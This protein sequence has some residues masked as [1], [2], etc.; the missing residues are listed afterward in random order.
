MGDDAERP[1][2]PELEDW[3]AWVWRCWERLR[4]DRQWIAA[5]MEAMPGRIPWSTIDRWCERHGYTAEEARFLERCLAALDV[6]FLDRWHT[7]RQG[8]AKRG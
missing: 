2:G 8:A 3:L 5:G 1:T 4:H 6:D 7:Q